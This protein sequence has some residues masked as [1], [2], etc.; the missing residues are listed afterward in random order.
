MADRH[1]YTSGGAGGIEKTVA[2]L[3]SAFPAAVSVDTFKRFDIAKGNEK[4]MV[5]LLKFIGVLDAEG[6]RVPAAAQVFAQ[7][8]DA[9]FQADLLISFVPDTQISL[10]CTP[11]ER[12]S[13]NPANLS[14]FFG[15]PM[16]P[17]HS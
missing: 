14:R 8:D 11:K 10:P 1:P 4:A 2:Q 6:K 16:K 12:G 9:D 5:D 17:V 7:H 13:W 15:Q 3:R